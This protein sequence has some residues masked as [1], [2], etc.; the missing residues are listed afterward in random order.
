LQASGG[1]LEVNPENP[2]ETIWNSVLHV[3]SGGSIP[4]W[5]AN[6][7]ALASLEPMAKLKEGLEKEH[8]H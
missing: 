3:H 7:I 4:L 8:Q 6:T 2:A 5:L 1:V